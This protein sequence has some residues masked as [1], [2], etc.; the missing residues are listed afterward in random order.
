MM[1]L[2]RGMLVF[3]MLMSCFAFSASGSC[4]QMKSSRKPDPKWDRDTVLIRF[5]YKQSALYHAFTFDVIDSIVDIL[6]RNKAATVSIDG[7]AYKDEGSDTICYYLSLNRALFLQ[8]YILGR[9]IDSS[10]ILSVQAYGRRK[11]ISQVK[12]KDGFLINCRAEIMLNYPAKVLS[13]E[14]TDRDE[15]GIV[16]ARD[17]CPDIFGHA[18]KK[19]C[20]DTDFVLIPFEIRQSDLYGTAFKILD[21]V[22]YVL[23][24]N[25][26]VTIAIQGHAYKTEGVNNVCD[27]IATE[28]ADMVKNYLLSRNFSMARITSVKGFSC[29]RPLNAGKTPKDIT[30][31]YR[32][33]ILF[34]RK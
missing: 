21:S 11:A 29:L 1:N 2:S 23:R 25:P 5:D 32:T 27:R 15:D 6:K 18:D 14:E 22:L 30:N 4:Q 13:P 19:G 17:H 20:P 3:F 33:E 16:D 9:G 31:N 8:T 34:N 26:S 12:D 7:Y 10:R 24:E 28:R